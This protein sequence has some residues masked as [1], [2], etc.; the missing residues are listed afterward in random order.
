MFLMDQYVFF[1]A[2]AVTLA[3]CRYGT[4][5]YTIYQGKTKP[6][7]FSW[8]LWGMV[9][10][11]G[12]FAQF[13]MNAGPSAWALAFVSVTCTLIAIFAFFI[14]ERDYKKSDW[15]ALIAC[16]IAIPL[17]RATQNPLIAIL[18]IMMIDVLTYWPTIR[19]SY[20]NPQTEPPI[21][22]GFAGMRYFLMLFAVPNPTWETLLYPFFLMATDWG[23]AIYIVIRRA[24]LGY[25]LHEYSRKTIADEAF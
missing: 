21:S 24:Q 1:A 17:W 10:G 22:Y 20:H 8:L 7:A 19:K 18:V 4:Y 23:F 3:L 11:V 9:T 5:F 16:I 2:A 15:F 6:H 25:P 13:E 12:T 14:G